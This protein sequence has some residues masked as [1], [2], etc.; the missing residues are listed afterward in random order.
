MEV[1]R[2]GPDSTEDQLCFEGLV[3]VSSDEGQMSIHCCGSETWRGRCQMRG[4][5]LIIKPR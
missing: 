1:S 4:I 5:F 2:F 3:H